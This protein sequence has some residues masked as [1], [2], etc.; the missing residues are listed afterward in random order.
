LAETPPYLNDALRWVAAEVRYP[1]VDALEAS[2]PKALRDQLREQ[3]P[4]PEQVTEMVMGFGAAGPSAEQVIKHRFLARDR[5]TSATVSR[6]SILLETTFYPGWTAMSAQLGTLLTALGETLLPAGVLRVGL[7]YIDEVRVPTQVADVNDWA[8]WISDT[9]V[10]PLSIDDEAT[11]TTATTVLQ[12]GEP[13][14]HVTTFR[15]APFPAG[16][17]VQSDGPLRMP[18]E[19]PDGPYFLLDTDASWADPS[20]QV[21][22]FSPARILE[23]ADELHAPCKR[24][25]EAAVTDRLRDEVLRRPPEEVWG[26]NG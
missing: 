7:R 23:I 8:G 12:Y 17:T 15:A 21:P 5:L 16:R 19:T 14:G 22:E 6:D 9:L 2:I 11:P 10:A 20:R 1:S 26:Q 25:F 18:R 4:I 24:L 13:P 3:F